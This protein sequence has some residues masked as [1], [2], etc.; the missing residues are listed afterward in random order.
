MRLFALG[1]TWTQIVLLAYNRSEGCRDD[2]CEA[3]MPKQALSETAMI[4]S[5]LIHS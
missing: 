2:A 5:V 4:I 3:L 1:Q